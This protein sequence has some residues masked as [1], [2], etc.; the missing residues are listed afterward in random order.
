MMLC[1]FIFIF[2]LVKRIIRNTVNTNTQINYHSMNFKV[3][4]IIKIL[5]KKI[6][7]FTDCFP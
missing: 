2:I 3:I 6:N 1:K 7:F 5:K 4:C